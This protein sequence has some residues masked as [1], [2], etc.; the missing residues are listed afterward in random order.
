MSEYY[1]GVKGQAGEAT[2][3][4]AKTS[5]LHVYAKSYQTQIDVNYWW[6]DT[7]ERTYVSI[8]AKNL[9]TGTS[10]TLYSGPEEATEVVRTK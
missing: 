5:G 1:G 2:R 4:G 9:H 3:R 7:E 8:T 6:N 10:R